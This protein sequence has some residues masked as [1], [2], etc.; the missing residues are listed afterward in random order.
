MRIAPAFLACLTLALPLSIASGQDSEPKL[1][2]KPSDRDAV[3]ALF[4]DY[5]KQKSEG[6]DL[7]KIASSLDKLEADLEKRAKSLKIVT[8]LDSTADMR[9]AMNSPYRP[10]KNVKKGF[11]TESSI[12]EM[13][14]SGKTEV[15]YLYR[16][17]NKYSDKL[18]YPAIIAL[19]PKIEKV[20]AVKKWA[21]AAFP[22]A[23]SES[24]VIIVPL[25]LKSVAWSSL[26][27]RITAFFPLREAIAAYA[28]DRG[29]VFLDGSMD[30]A[31]IVPLYLTEHPG[32]F[33]GGI[34][35]EP[36]AAPAT[37]LLSNAR[38]E[39]MLLVHAAGGEAANVL[40]QF[41]QDCTA[42]GVK[43]TSVES[44]VEAS[45]KA[46]DAGAAAIAKFVAETKKV[47][48]P[49]DIKF[50]TVSSQ[51]VNCYWLE[52][53]KFEASESKPVT[54]EA[55]V[56]RTTNEIRIT[57]PPQVTEVAIY[58]NQDLVDM[59]KEIKVLVTDKSG[60]TPKSVTRYNGRKGPVLDSAL[61]FWF[62]NRTG[63]YGEVYTN[64]IN[65]TL[66]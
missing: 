5:F 16:L 27:G 54:V 59:G 21:D 52:L 29:R 43:T 10:D 58:L 2:L 48:T 40:K 57:A 7:K 30:A 17:P 22:E 37:T 28:V 44:P 33:A 24:T 46:G 55:S 15:K 13:L 36:D 14:P 26:D 18:L 20:D 23:I 53:L 41:E 35:R 39:P 11:F 8:L 6:R 61:A 66:K 31:P 64:S 32:I 3:A 56:D 51:S 12:N 63:N 45:G 42:A 25:N 9:S 19:P 65:V 34:L 60:E 49:R 1:L 50:T 4:A 62:S 38:S 47:Y